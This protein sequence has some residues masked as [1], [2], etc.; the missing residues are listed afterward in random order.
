M[1][2]LDASATF[3]DDVAGDDG[4]GPGAPTTTVPPD[5]ATTTARCRVRPDAAG[6]DRRRAAAGVDRRRLDDP[7]P[8]RVRAAPR[9][10]GPGARRRRPLRGLHGAHPPRLLRLA[11]RT[12]R[13]HG[14][15]R[16]RGGHADVRRQRRPGDHRGRRHRTPG[17]SAS[18]AGRPSTGAGSTPSWTSSTRPTAWCCG[19]C[20]RRSATA[21]S[22]PASGSSTASTAPPPRTARGSCSSRPPRWSATPDGAYDPAQRQGDGIHLSREGADRLAQHLLDLI[23]AELPEPATTTTT[24]TTTPDD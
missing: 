3:A 8:R 5:G 13:R 6:R 14:V 15:H 24:T 16:G 1:L 18:P 7:G 12:C 21:S 9:R 2:Q 19:C 4:S 10:R 17:R 11:G 22:T 23:A 20:S